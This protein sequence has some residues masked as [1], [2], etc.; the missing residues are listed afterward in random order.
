[1]DKKMM[2]INK[3]LLLKIKFSLNHIL[4]KNNTFKISIAIYK[5][6]EFDY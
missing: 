6:L 4:P 3:N 1:M 2:N 5:D